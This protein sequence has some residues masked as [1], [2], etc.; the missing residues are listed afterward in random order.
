[1]TTF[2]FIQALLHGAWLPF[3]RVM[4]FLFLFL[5]SSVE[6]DMGIDP[7]PQ[8]SCSMLSILSI[9][10]IPNFMHLYYGID[11]RLMLV[12]IKKS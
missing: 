1:M 10:P 6:V 7:Q 3:K 12:Y 5:L 8:A 2:F 11:R 9:Y 4:M